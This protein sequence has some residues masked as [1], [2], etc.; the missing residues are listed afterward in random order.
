MRRPSYLI[1]E[2]W[3][4]D[5]K[6]RFIVQIQNVELF[7][8]KLNKKIFFKFQN[9]ILFDQK[10]IYKQQKHDRMLLA[11]SIGCHLESVDQ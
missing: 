9:R 10:L 2:H 3:R 7:D 5:T 6:F 1:V 4:T 8:V 11:F